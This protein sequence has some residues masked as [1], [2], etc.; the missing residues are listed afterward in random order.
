MNKLGFG[1]MRLPITEEG[2]PKSVNQPLVEAMVD[3]YIEKGFNY[4]DTAYPYHQGMS[5]AAA[6]KALVERYPRERFLLADKM[7]TF[8]VTSAAD[9]SRFFDEQRERCGVEY[10]DYYMLHNLGVKNYASTLEYGGF[11]YINK[12]K[13][14]GK[15][16][17]IGL[18]YHD[19]AELLDAILARH[20]EME[21]V[22]LQ[23]NYID[24]DSESIESR[25]CC[26]VAVK[27]EKP[28]IAMEPVKGG[29]LAKVPAEVDALFRAYHPEM[30]PASWAIRFAASLEPVFMV[31]SG[32]SSLEQVIDNTEY[33]RQMTPL[34]GAE[35]EIIRK[36]TGIINGKTAIPCTACGYCVD[37]CPSRIPI[38]QYFSLYNNE[39][40]FGQTSS[41]VY[42]ANLAQDFGK[43][44]DC[45]ECGQCEEH[46]PQH[47]EIIKR[48][49]EVAQMFGA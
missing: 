11:E 23:I 9:Y 32:M 18:S 1:M 25:K 7:P 43:A 45:T 44:S 21:F 8:L 31:L 19:K 24:W 20:P 41:W 46:C 36:A 42:Y 48:I 4:F 14:E 33:M 35:K 16:K 10:F 49:K 30:S 39:K 17:R 28:I 2:N 47:I 34:D 27:H 12:L 13:D 3:C 15:A 29:S 6:R 5:E 26:E 22:Q 40:Q 38:P 37:D